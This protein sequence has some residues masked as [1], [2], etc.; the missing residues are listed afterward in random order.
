MEL[1][2]TVKV[3]LCGGQTVLLH[4][5]D[6]PIIAV[7]DTETSECWY[8]TGNENLSYIGDV[9]SI[10]FKSTADCNEHQSFRVGG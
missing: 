2:I 1:F 7:Q 4:S 9:G 3:N 10:V 8:I 6:Y 5:L